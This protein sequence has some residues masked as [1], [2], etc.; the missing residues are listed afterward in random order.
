MTP[1]SRSLVSSAP[2]VPRPEFERLGAW[3][4]LLGILSTF[5]GLSWDIQWHVDVGPDTFWTVPHLFV[6]SGAALSGLASLLVVLLATARAS[7]EAAPHWITILG[8]RFRGPVGFF[9]SGFGALAFLLFGLFDQWWHLVY[10]FD[11]VLDSP[12]HIG[13]LLSMVVTMIGAALIFVQG[14]QVQVWGFVTSLA[15]S[16]AFAL[17][18]FSLMMAQLEQTWA[19]LVFPGLFMG[20][21]L[22]LAVSVTR[23]V[24]WALVLTLL[25]A[26]FRA[27]NWY[28]VPWADTVYAH[29]LGYTLRESA[30]GYAFVPALAPLLS[31]LVG[32]VVTGVLAFWRARRWNA[33]IGMAAAL[34]VTGPLLFVGHPFVPVTLDP[35][36]LAVGAAVAGAAGWLGWQLGVV[37]RHANPRLE[38]R[39]TQ[40]VTSGTV[41]P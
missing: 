2:N 20:L 17:P 29:A 32:L 39:G 34:A 27:I 26:A 28:G 12:P 5:F 11:V 25:V 15:V 6:Y 7:S 3:V 18:V 23:Q 1:D 38:R 31:P 10:G 14:R 41:R 8:G 33:Q 40:G 13:L 9:V 4:A 22:A 30:E 35:V 24:R 19:F 37:I 16:V 21:A 36:V